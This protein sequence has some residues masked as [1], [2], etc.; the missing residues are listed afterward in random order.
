M[1]K[2]ILIPTDGSRVAR[3]AI[4]AG[5]KLARELGAS[6]IGYNASEPIE[7]FYYEGG[8][9]SLSARKTLEERKEAQAL[10]YVAE[11]EKAA[12]A[13]GVACNAVVT[14]TAMPYQ[15]IL[16]TARKKKCDLIFM[17][18]HGRGG[19]ASLLLGSV[20]QKVLTHSKMPVLIYR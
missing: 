5:V 3:K 4:A 13:A 14:V 16:A 10:R 1:F 19:L 17:S 12:H 20:T 18:S 8:G 11:I 2:R 15:G 7:G 6:V 9:R